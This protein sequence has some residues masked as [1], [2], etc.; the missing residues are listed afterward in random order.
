MDYRIYIAAVR[1]SLQSIHYAS[2]TDASKRKV[3]QAVLQQQ[4]WCEKY[5]NNI[6]LKYGVKATDL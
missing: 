6:I 2:W 1:I 5:E 3:L 4:I